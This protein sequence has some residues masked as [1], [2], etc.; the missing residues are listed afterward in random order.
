[1]EG[2]EEVSSG[3][4]DTFFVQVHDVSPEQ[5]H[6]VIK[7]LRYSTA[8]DIIQQVRESLWLY[9]KISSVMSILN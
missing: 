7:A 8:Q 5:P 1:M 3:E 6:T 2:V 4:E 9:W